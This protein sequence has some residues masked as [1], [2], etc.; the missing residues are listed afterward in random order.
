V[1][2]NMTVLDDYH[3]LAA[4]LLGTRP[5]R[6]FEIGTYR[7]VTSDFFLQVLPEVEVVSIAFVPEPS[8]WSNFHRKYNNTDLP[9]DMV[10]R[11]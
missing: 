7:G 1:A 2:N 3:A 10:G 9:V 11:D 6:I 4:I 5:R 8:F